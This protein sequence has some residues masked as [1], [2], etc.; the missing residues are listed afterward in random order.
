LV[1]S[2]NYCSPYTDI[3]GKTNTWGALP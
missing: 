1:R 2:R 3:G